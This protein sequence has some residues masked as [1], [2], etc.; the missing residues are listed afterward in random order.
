MAL[1]KRLSDLRQKRIY[2]CN[3]CGKEIYGDHVEIT[4]KRRS[5]L[6]IHYRCMPGGRS[7][8]EVK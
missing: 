5:K 2:L 7:S 1:K 4:T 6:H 8:H 3:F